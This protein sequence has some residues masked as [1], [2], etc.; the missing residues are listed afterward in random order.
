MLHDTVCYLTKVVTQM[1]VDIMYFTG[2][3]LKGC[4]REKSV[5]SA[6]S[7][8]N[9]VLHF[10]GAVLIDGYLWTSALEWNGYYRVDIE[11]GDAEFLGLFE[12]A[13]VL[14]DKM[15]YQ[16][17]SYGKYIFFVP[18]FSD[19]L[20]RL[21]TKTLEAKY[22]KLPEGIVVEK[23]KFR[24][25]NLYNGQIFMFPHLGDDVCIFHIEEERFE[26]DKKWVNDYLA[27]EMENKENRFLQ[28]CEKDKAVYLPNF[29]GSIMMKYDME[30]YV[31]EM[32]VFHK[33]EKKVVDVIEYGERE[34]LVL[35]G[36]GNIWKYNIDSMHK[37]L[38]YRHERD[39]DFPYIHILL[40]KDILYLI[41][42]KLEEIQELTW[43]TRNKVPCPIGW[44]LRYIEVGI[45]NVFQGYLVEKEHFWLY[46]CKGNMLLNM[47]KG[48]LYLSGVEIFD[49][50]P[51][52]YKAIKRYLKDKRIDGMIMESRVDLE[53]YL[54]GFVDVNI[55]DDVDNSDI[56]G[57]CIWNQTKG[58]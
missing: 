54:N 18:W 8:K 34:L 21:D 20:V 53:L 31:S 30:R 56:C 15:F 50:S 9:R 23:A 57:I 46:P 42:T 24:A 14:A 17:L 47:K 43:K 22:W 27:L 1:F 26:C 49:D 32:I 28:G 13:D 37:K 2:Q 5:G 11:T 7:K 4:Q 36:T 19:Y 39:N 16:I 38:I 35:T 33:E 55:R 45:D 12:Y 51:N 10:I 58:E 48:Q 44:K 25:A 3:N 52:R 6:G 41:P 29:G 40:I